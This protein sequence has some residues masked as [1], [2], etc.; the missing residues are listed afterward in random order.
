M[1]S[2]AGGGRRTGA[3][4]SEA[5]GG[6]RVHGEEFTVRN[7][8]DVDMGAVF[9]AAFVNA[10]TAYAVLDRSF[11]YVPYKTGELMSTGKVGSGSDFG[12]NDPFGGRMPT[13]SLRGEGEGNWSAKDLTAGFSG[14]QAI[15][16]VSMR[17][18]I[19]VRTFQR[20]WVGYT[21]DHAALVH[22]NPYNYKFKQGTGPRPTTIKQDHFL[23][24]A[25]RDL[26]PVYS[27]A[28]HI[29]LATVIEA[30]GARAETQKRGLSAGTG[31]PRLVKP[32]G[33]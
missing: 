24:Q 7:I 33:R 28:H 19:A 8:R 18:G 11:D 9:A 14:A 16:S 23:L 2:P 32:G 4:S 5:G 6:I 3:L 29:A 10:R 26:E 17:S 30:I 27:A 21:A 13:P 31:R 12:D 20:Y 22:E 15:T 25:Y 1:A